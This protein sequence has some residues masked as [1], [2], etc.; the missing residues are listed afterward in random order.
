MYDQERSEN[1][2]PDN[3][4][5]LACTEVRA[6]AV[7]TKCNAVTKSGLPFWVQKGMPTNY[8]R[9]EASEYCVKDL[10]IE[11][12]KE[13]DKCAAKAERYVNYVFDKCYKD[14]SPFSSGGLRRNVSNII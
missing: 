14:R 2:N 4:K 11:H 10:A 5:H 3:C 1:F 12:L 13:R 6:A 8:D 9:I 7:N